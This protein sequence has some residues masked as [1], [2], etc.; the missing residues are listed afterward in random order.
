[1]NMFLLCPQGGHSHYH[2]PGCQQRP[3]IWLP[4]QHANA[5]TESHNT[6]GLL[7]SVSLAERRAVTRAWPCLSGVKVNG[8]PDRRTLWP[9]QTVATTATGRL[10]PHQWGPS[11]CNR[12]VSL[13]HILSDCFLFSLL[14]LYVSLFPVLSLQSIFITVSCSLSSI[15]IYHCFLF[16]LSINIP[17]LSSSVS[18]IF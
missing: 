11:V 8:W 1:M 14:F 17:L 18:S 15:Y 5:Q 13:S 16:Y 2:S 7:P 12:T 9:Q 4:H 3:H 6:L 10:R